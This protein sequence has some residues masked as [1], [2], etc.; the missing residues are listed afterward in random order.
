MNGPVAQHRECR[1]QIPGGL[2]H[3][4]DDG[5]D[6]VQLTLVMWCHGT[7]GLPSLFSFFPGSSA[8]CLK[9]APESGN[10]PNSGFYNTCKSGVASRSWR[11][12]EKGM[13]SAVSVAVDTAK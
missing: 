8:W 5:D 1:I 3:R 13:T 2:E 11:G 12:R 6:G 9:L 4:K 7:P 10:I